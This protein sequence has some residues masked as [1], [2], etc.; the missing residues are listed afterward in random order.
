MSKTPSGTWTGARNG[1]IEAAVLAA[2]IAIMYIAAMISAGGVTAAHLPVFAGAA[3]AMRT[4]AAGA[5]RLHGTLLLPGCYRI[6]PH[7]PAMLLEA[8]TLGPMIFL[9][10]GIGFTAAL[11]A[12]KVQAVIPVNDIPVADIFHA[13]GAAGLLS[14]GL[15]RGALK[16]LSGGTGRGR[17]GKR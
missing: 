4:L 16:F 2:V 9:T 13:G 10:G 1:A 15:R 5:G 7:A 17:A 6:A 11:L 3:V 8:A 12:A 14:E